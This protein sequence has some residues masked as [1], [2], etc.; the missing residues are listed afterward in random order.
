[1]NE[2]HQPVSS[3]FSAAM[4]KIGIDWI[5]VNVMYILFAAIVCNVL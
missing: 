2:L 4:G 5:E 1:M 3:L